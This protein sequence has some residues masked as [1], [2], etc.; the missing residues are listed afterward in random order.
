M[1]KIIV[2]L[3]GLCLVPALFAQAGGPLQTA[4]VTLTS[5]Q[6]Q[7]LKAGPVTLIAAPGAGSYINV[8]AVVFQY[9]A[10]TAPYVVASGGHFSMLIGAGAN[11]NGPVET[12]DLSATGFIDKTQNHIRVPRIS[13]VGDS[14]G[15]L[16]N[17]A[18]QVTNDGG[19]E[20]TD[21]NGTVTITVSYTVVALQ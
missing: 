6:L 5:A 8:V 12:S 16:E 10:G 13:S 18:L 19:A 1:R 3:V 7:N 21:G 2:L 9:K 11:G 20:W 14:Q 17:Q 4:T 15:N